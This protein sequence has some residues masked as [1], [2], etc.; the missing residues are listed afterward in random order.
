MG[1]AQRYFIGIDI[2]A[3]LAAAISTI[4]RQSFDSRTMLEPLKPHITLLHPGLVEEMPADELLPAVKSVA[5]QFFPLQLSLKHIGQFQTRAVF[6]A[7]ESARLMELY[8]ALFSLLP[9]NTV[10]QRHPIRPFLPHITIAQSKRSH[11][12]SPAVYHLA[13]QQLQ[14]SLPQQLICDHLTYFG[15]SRPRNYVAEAI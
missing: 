3:K 2:P 12:L 8:R 11:Q 15:Q 7:V 14:Q 5:E 9:S 13:V 6:V 10:I 1:S 4:Q